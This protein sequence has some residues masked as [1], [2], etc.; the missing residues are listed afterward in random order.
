[1][2]KKILYPLTGIVIFLLL[3]IIISF[4][5]SGVIVPMPW[6]VGIKIMHL[7]SAPGTYVHLGLT[8]LRSITG[9]F[10][11]LLAGTCIGIITGSFIPCEKTFYIP[12]LLLHGAPPLLWII[13]LML[14]LGTGNASP[15]TVVFLIVLPVVIINVQEGMK[16]I[17]KEKWEM[18]TL[19]APSKRM[20]LLYLIIPSLAGFYRSIVKIGIVLAFKSCL[21]GEWFGAEDGIGRIINEYFYTFDMRSFYSVSFLFLTMLGGI[22][23]AVNSFAQRVLSRKKSR[24][25]YPESRIRVPGT[26]TRKTCSFIMHKVTFS[27]GN[28]QV[29]N[30]ISFSVEPQQQVLITGDSG[31][32][33]TTLAKI[34]AGLIQPEKGNVIIPENTCLLFQQGVLLPYLDCFGNAS[35]SARWKNDDN[36]FNKVLY[37]LK[38]CGLD[39]YTHHFP[40]QLSGGMKRRLSLARTLVRSPDFIIIDEPFS[41]LHKQ[42]REKLWDLVFSIFALKD[43]PMIIITHHPEELSQLSLATYTLS[44]GILYKQ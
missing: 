44:G 16:S 34:A 3:W 10:F 5:L 8:A 38:L 24:I 37:Y 1:M 25:I 4:L 33:K 43:I 20:I 39:G 27:Y 9:F 13:P 19:Y 42:A 32:G 36:I 2:N 29:L 23:F 31:A 11:A 6:D 14:I 28:K 41:G 15:I 30:N 7:L 18:F 12:L 17:T 26:V 40:G 21:L 35:L 22:T